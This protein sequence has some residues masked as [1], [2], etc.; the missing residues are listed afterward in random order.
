M[1]VSPEHCPVPLDH[2][3]DHAVPK[4]G[5]HAVLIRHA[6]HKMTARNLR[7]DAG[8]EVRLRN[9]LLV[10]V[11]DPFH[12]VTLLFHETRERKIPGVSLI[13]L[14]D[15]LEIIAARRERH[16]PRRVVE[17]ITEFIACP[18]VPVKDHAT[19]I[20]IVLLK[21]D[22][23]HGIIRLHERQN[24]I[25][26]PESTVRAELPGH[27]VTKHLPVPRHLVRRNRHRPI[28][29]LGTGN[30][31]FGRH[32]L[33]VVERHQ[34]NHRHRRFGGRQGHRSVL[35]EIPTVRVQNR[36]GH[37]GIDDDITVIR[38]AEHA[39]CAEVHRNV[40]NLET[41]E[42]RHDID[43][44]PLIKELRERVIHP[45]QHRK[46]PAVFHTHIQHIRP[47]HE[48]IVPRAE[49][50]VKTHVHDPCRAIR[51]RERYRV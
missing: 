40:R 30:R 48:I 23:R 14:I 24:V 45:V 4:K 49:T 34:M 41:R 22:L 25:R 17:R 42:G 36:N 29:A 50:T 32:A 15:L 7:L 20:V 47:A 19:L 12:A 44:V 35:P 33:P 21:T 18:E 11:P 43:P 26:R 2:G 8:R 39:V 3:K 1:T 37:I 16:L 6:R 31:R 27:H 28:K 5:R 51:S 9:K 10:L 38:R 46:K 13:K